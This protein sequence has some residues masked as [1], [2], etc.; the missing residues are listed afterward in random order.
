MRY[1]QASPISD[2]QVQ[3]A[4]LAKKYLPIDP[5]RQ[6]S[7]QHGGEVYTRL[8]LE[9]ESCPWAHG[10]SMVFREEWQESRA[11]VGLIATLSPSYRVWICRYDYHPGAHHNPDW[12]PPFE[13]GI[14]RFHRHLF[15]NRAYRE[16]GPGQW[17]ACATEIEQPKNPLPPQQYLVHLKRV[18][19]SDLKVET[20]D[21]WG[22]HALFS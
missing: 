5:D 17:D 13:I 15:T 14:K 9:V 16:H 21:R 8:P 3:E 12:F 20:L 6:K 2:E 1:R 22:Y 4:L 10:F 18:F 19:M 7:D 11:K